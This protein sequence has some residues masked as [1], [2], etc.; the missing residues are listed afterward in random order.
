VS[1]S[2]SEIL[3][4]AL[5]DYG[6]AV[7]VG[8]DQTF[9]K[10]TV[11]SVFPLPPGLGALKVTTALFFRPGG[12]STQASGVASDVVVPSPFNLDLFGERKLPYSLPPQSVSPF[13]SEEANAPNGDGWTPVAAGL[14]SQL[15][16]RSEER[17]RADEALRKVRDELAERAKD[18]GVL[19][20][21]EILKPEKKMD[22]AGLGAGLDAGVPAGAGSAET[23]A[24]DDGPGSRRS[25]EPTPQLEEALRV[26]ADLVVLGEAREVGA[27]R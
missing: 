9:G 2:A 24:T 23:A 6:R 26:L 27:A 3:A 12:A 4:G 21:A 5:Q 1:A 15:R 22:T 11:Q 18:D 17:Q 10:G 14:V 20:I 16:Q 13:P 19:E 7:I 25:N 8:D